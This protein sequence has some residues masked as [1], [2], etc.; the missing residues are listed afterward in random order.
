MRDFRGLGGWVRWWGWMGGERF[1]GWSGKGVI[2]IAS[3][4]A[5]RLN[6][7]KRS[8]CAIVVRDVRGGKHAGECRS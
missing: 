1:E 7:P 5:T 8:I 2:G 3:F 6:I 4:P